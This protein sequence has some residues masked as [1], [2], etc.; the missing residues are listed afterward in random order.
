MSIDQPLHGIRVLDLSRLLPGPYASWVLSSLGAEVV[1]VEDTAGGDYSRGVP[2]F[3]DDQGALFHVINRGKRSLA[4][5]L[6]A[7]AGQ[8]LLLRLLP[9]FDVVLEQFRPGV[10]D[11]LGLGYSALSAAHPGVILCSLTGY[12]Q[13]GPLAQAAGHDVNFEAL[14]G[15]LWLQGEAGR[16]PLLPAVPQADLAS[17][18]FAVIAIQ[19]ALRERERTG[20]GT[21]IDLSMAHSMA[22]LVAPFA[23]EWTADPRAAG[24]GGAMLNGG[25]AQYDTYATVDGG[26][27]AVAALEPKFMQRFSA[28]VERPHWVEVMPV[29]G[30]PGQ[31]QLRVELTEVVGAHDTAWW[32]HRLAD[33]D[34]AVSVVLDPRQ[35]TEHPQ[36]A[37]HATEVA[38]G[39]GAAARWVELPLGVPPQGPAPRQGQH[40]G[41]ILIEA[42][43]SADEIAALRRDGVIR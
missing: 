4:V 21:W 19:G 26:W 11:R 10:I 40:T 15:N 18:L 36:L 35:A 1:R 33:V 28:L 39:Q 16:K 31:E 7:E 14:A 12:G 37:P 41:A 2:P 34:C 25:V 17:S 29:P 20:E 3:I 23:A 8:E 22:A 5:D 13:Q 24:R 9:S 6:K 27:V 30:A 32:T 43:W 38:A 42:G